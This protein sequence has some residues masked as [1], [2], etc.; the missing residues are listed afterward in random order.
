MSKTFKMDY[1][2]EN[3]VARYKFLTLSMKIV[4]EVIIFFKMDLEFH[5]LGDHLDH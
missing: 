1:G 5:E 4:F 3:F 2:F